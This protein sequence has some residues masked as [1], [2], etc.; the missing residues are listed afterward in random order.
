MIAAFDVAAVLAAEQA[1]QHDLESGVLMDRAATGLAR[2]VIGLLQES[3]GRVR[4]AHIAIAVGGGNNGGDAL[5]AGAKLAQRGVS[6]TAV[7][8]ATSAHVAGVAALL[9]ANGR[10]V[11]WHEA[12]SDLSLQNLFFDA[13]VIIDGIVGLGGSGVLR[14]AAAA[15]VE[16]INASGALVV[17]V[18]LPSGV[19]ASDVAGGLRVVDIGIT[20]TLGE[21]ALIALEAVD[22]VAF[23]PEPGVDDY[24]YR[25]GVVG[26]AAGSRQYPGAALLTVGAARMGDVGMVRYLDRGDDVAQQVLAIF[27]DVV[28]SGDDPGDSTRV[29]AWACGP[30]FAG[31]SELAHDDPAIDAVLRTSVPVVLDAGALMSVAGSPTLRT[32]IAQRSA[33][34]VITPHAGEAAALA[35]AIG[36]TTDLGRLALAQGLAKGLNVV[37]VLK[38]PASLIAAPS[39]LVLVDTMGGAELSTAGSGDVLTGLAAAVLAGANARGDID[40]HD[41]AA[42]AVAAAVWLHGQAGQLA[43]ADGWPVTALD[44]RDHLGAAVALVRR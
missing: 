2:A 13:D 15:V 1:H 26:I 10:V 16:L 27:P 20:D 40:D 43:A 33:I 37:V 9:R 23:V 24:K 21:P 34:T 39:G 14:P 11:Q 3:R 12:E 5:F 25:R 17:A 7:C 44:V 22:V 35:A 8:V 18:D 36:L 6:V 31:A 42:V 28:A 29:T 19:A 30:G 41:D 32:Q 38:G 4:G